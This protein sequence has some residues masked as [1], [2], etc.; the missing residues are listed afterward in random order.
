MIC[1]MC[2]KAYE[3]HFNSRYCSVFCKREWRLISQRAWHE[4]EKWKEAAK[5]WY[6]NPKRVLSEKRYRD[7]PETK[8]LWVKRVMKCLRNN[9]LLKQKKILWDKVYWYKRRAIIK[10]LWWI[11]YNILKEKFDSLWNKC[12]MCWSIDNT[13]IDHIIPLSK[14]GTNHI[15]NLQPLCRSCNGRKGNKIL[16]GNTL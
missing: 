7:K 9:P 3:W 1:W 12:L 15:D 11:D 16:I 2:E 14:W 13:Q 4:S 5:R 8:R 10:L 6:M